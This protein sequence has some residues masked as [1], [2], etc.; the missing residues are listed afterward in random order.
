LSY[1]EWENCCC[2]SESLVA[3]MEIQE[4]DNVRNVVR[5]GNIPTSTEYKLG[6]ILFPSSTVKASKVRVCLIEL[7]FIRHLPFCSLAHSPLD[8]LAPSLN[9]TRF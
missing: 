9:N 2:C 5:N 7:L 6:E 4:R 8:L 3:V 1:Y